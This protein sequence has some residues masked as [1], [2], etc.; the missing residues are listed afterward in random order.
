MLGEVSP[1]ISPDEN[2][3]GLLKENVT[4]NRNKEIYP[5]NWSIHYDEQANLK[6]F[7][8]KFVLWNIFSFC[9]LIITSALVESSRVP[10]ENVGGAGGSDYINAVFVPVSIVLTFIIFLGNILKCDTIYLNSKTHK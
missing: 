5:G 7:F 1:K 9:L 8:L 4:R 3:A 6:C 10:F 2:P